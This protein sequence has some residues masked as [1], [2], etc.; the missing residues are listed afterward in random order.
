[1][2]I[3]W[4]SRII[5]VS[6]P[7]RCC[8]TTEDHLM[9]TLAAALGQ[10]LIQKFSTIVSALA[11]ILAATEG[12]EMHSAVAQT[13]AQ[14]PPYFNR[15]LPVEERVKDLIRR[16]TL[17]E[18]VAQL[19]TTLSDP[20]GQKLIPPEG[21]GGVGPM[22]RPLTAEQAAERANMIQKMAFGETR[23]GIPVMIHDEAV[24]G[25]LANKAT[26]FPQA[27]ALASTWDTDL[28]SRVATVI[29]KETR[30]RGIRQVL[31]PVINIAHDVRWG[32]VEETYGEDPYL[33]ARMGVAFCSA[34]ERQG[35][36]TTPK[37][38]AANVGDGGRDSYPIQFSER[39][40]REVYFPPFKA[41]VQEGHASSVM[42]A[43]NSLDGLPCSANPWLLTDVLRKEWGFGGFVVSDYGSAAGI[44]N[45][46]FVAATEKDAAA[47]AVQAGLDVE[48]PSIY[49]Y[50]RPLID[51]VKERLVPISALD[52]AVKHVLRVKFHLGMFEE[53]YVDPKAATAINDAEEHRALAREAARKAIVLLKNERS[54]LPLKK[55]LKS[56]A[57]IGPAADEVQLG[58]YSGYG[59]KTVS[60]FEGVKGAVTPSTRLLYAKGCEI[61]FTALPTIQSEDLY[62]PS[63]K[64]GEH[65]LRGEYFNNMTLS[66]SPVL[67]R[68]DKRVYFEWAMGSPDSSIPV[69][70]FS[71]RWT[72]KIVPPVSGVYKLGASTDDGL[73]LYLDGKLLIDSWFDRGATLDY[74]ELK[75]EAGRAYDLRM[76]YYENEGWSY[77]NLVWDVKERPNPLLQSALD[78]A[79][80]AEVALVAVR[81]IEGEGYDRASLDLPTPEEELINTVAATGTPTIVILVDGSAVSMGRWKENVAGIVQAWYGG[82]EAGNGLADVLFGDENP[83]GKLPITFPQFAGQCPLYYSHTPT[84][85]GDDYSDMSGKPLFPFGFGLSYTTFEYS[86][87]TIDPPSIT[88]KGSVTLSVD[89]RNTG[90][91]RGDE[92]VQLYFHDQTASVARPTKEL[93]GFSR[94]SVEPG[95]TRTVRFTIGP[96]E[97]SFL[98]RNLKAVVEPGKILLMVGSS[99]EDIRATGSFQ[100]T[101]P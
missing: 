58:G 91:R 19:Q 68:T 47:L 74:V 86:N 71:V 57:I 5:A 25:L 98:N 35:V 9:K 40:L 39:L 93:K 17:E 24:H 36:A 80:H 61:G 78:S 43:Y 101:N 94:L 83:S 72:G 97:L 26:S 87:L 99:S 21:L 56:I 70:H 11:L 31:S 6:F 55:S 10:R 23:L 84:G 64:P 48:L 3:S 66:G 75:L 29:G 81:I 53:R 100:V 51:A 33:T 42:A 34:I 65:G 59:M 49:I 89:V 7:Y 92:V 15:N 77:A 37:H 82:E 12:I 8:F 76:E 41:C 30:S 2:K 95:E 54:V 22:L 14:E 50:G 90:N 73:R 1:L 44:M 62:P 13:K 4:I 46:H 60:L 45:K 63:A 27:I 96:G 18:K 85:R 32:R 67:V 52:E 69:D 79:K 28:M 16:M 88:P 38:F 20:K